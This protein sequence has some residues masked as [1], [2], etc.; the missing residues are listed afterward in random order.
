MENRESDDPE[1]EP[2]WW[3]RLWA[4]V[5]EVSVVGAFG[6]D[7]GRFLTEDADVDWATTVTQS[8]SAVVR[9]VWSVI[10]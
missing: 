3:V 1:N 4:V 9:A 10:A 5:I 8:T 2:P 7:L 6:L